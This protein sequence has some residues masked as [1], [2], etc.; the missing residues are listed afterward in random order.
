MTKAQPWAGSGGLGVSRGRRGAELQ[1]QAGWRRG[2]PGRAEREAGEAAHRLAHC[3]GGWGQV[4]LA[5]GGGN[6][7]H[8]SGAGEGCWPLAWLMLQGW[9]RLTALRPEPATRQSE[10]G[11]ERRRHSPGRR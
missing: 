6:M 1:R 4:W 3:A 10:A 5:P 11:A 7:R 8:D 2:V 9:R